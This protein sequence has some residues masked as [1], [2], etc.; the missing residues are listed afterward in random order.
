MN[1]SLRGDVLDGSSENSLSA[2]AVPV[3]KTLY[4]QKSEGGRCCVCL[5]CFACCRK[6]QRAAASP[7]SLQQHPA[8]ARDLRG[9]DEEEDVEPGVT[10]TPLLAEHSSGDVASETTITR[11]IEDGEFILEDCLSALT[12][13]TYFEACL[14]PLLTLYRNSAPGLAAGNSV[15]EMVLFALGCVASILGALDKSQV[16]PIVFAFVALLQALMTYHNPKRSSPRPVRADRHRDELGGIEQ[17][18]PAHAGIQG[19]L[20]HDDGE[21]GSRRGAGVGRLWGPWKGGYRR[22]QGG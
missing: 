1:S 2:A 7:A 8:A 18:G 6:R 19:V 9:Q 16:I 12:A 3:Q 4:E 11:A 22:D 15:V 14:Q 20:V 10:S 21:H 5:T 13:E 17:H